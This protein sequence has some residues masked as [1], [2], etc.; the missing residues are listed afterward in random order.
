LKYER[1][2][3][4]IVI[5]WKSDVC[6]M[7]TQRIFV[8]TLDIHTIYVDVF[9]SGICEKKNQ[10]FNEDDETGKNLGFL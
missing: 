3:E 2:G 9:S 7:D 8:D 4:G 5:R 10:G 6:S 1:C